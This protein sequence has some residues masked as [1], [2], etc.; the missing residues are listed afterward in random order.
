MRLE[1]RRWSAAPLALTVSTAGAGDGAGFRFMRPILY[2][3]R[4]FGRVDVTLSKA[5][6]L[7][8]A[9]LTRLLLAIL[10]VVTLGSV[11]AVSYA[12]GRAVALPV[13]QLKAA[14][15][16]AAGGDL[17]FRIS[18]H[19]KDEFGDLFDGFNRLAAAMQERLEVAETGPRAQIDVHPA[20]DTGPFAPTLATSAAVAS[21]LA[22]ADSVDD[23]DRT[24]ISSPLSDIPEPTAPATATDAGREIHGGLFE[25]LR[26]LRQA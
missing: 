18:H 8:V 26:Q 4:T 5:E 23:Q 1:A 20:I 16:D 12:A 21:A 24:Q 3:G 11:I 17:N 22:A 25:R 6:L 7:S 19:R 14:L 15:A 13:R 10:G 2:A 9:D